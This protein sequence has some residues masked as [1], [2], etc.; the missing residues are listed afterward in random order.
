MG[1]ETRDFAIGGGSGAGCG[2]LQFQTPRNSLGLVRIGGNPVLG[3]HQW[4]YILGHFWTLVDF[5]QN[6]GKKTQKNSNFARIYRNSE[7]KIW[8]VSLL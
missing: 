6:T 1:T 2:L 7:K 4:G 8:G 5:G 3:G